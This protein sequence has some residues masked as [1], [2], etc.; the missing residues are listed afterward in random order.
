MKKYDITILENMILNDKYSLT[1]QG[2]PLTD[3]TQS[4]KFRSW[5]IKTYPTKAME[6]NL[7]P[8]GPK[9]NATMQPIFNNSS[10]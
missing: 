5:F 4:N 8:T 3:T 6:L 7:D 9:D 1:E 10:Y 2:V